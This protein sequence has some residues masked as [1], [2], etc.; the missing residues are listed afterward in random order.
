VR[1]AGPRAAA[2][3][4]LRRAD[5]PTLATRESTILHRDPTF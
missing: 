4:G 5:N 2:G 3:R 1:A